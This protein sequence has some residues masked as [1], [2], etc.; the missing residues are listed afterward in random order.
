MTLATD[1]DLP[2]LRGSIAS[3][4]PVCAADTREQLILPIRRLPVIRKNLYCGDYSLAGRSGRLGSSGN[5]SRI[6]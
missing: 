6:S 3:L 2:T 4:R 5:Q 1:I